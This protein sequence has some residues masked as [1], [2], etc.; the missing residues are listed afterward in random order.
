[1]AKVENSY[2]V[3]SPLAYSQSKKSEEGADAIQTPGLG[4]EARV[5]GLNVR[6]V[7]ALL[8]GAG[9]MVSSK[10][11]RWGCQC[12]ITTDPRVN[13]GWT[14]DVVQLGV[15]VSVCGAGYA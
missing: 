4:H 12:N 2:A 8:T 1:M 3:E 13:A 15:R 5:G 14:V 9:A 7:D 10:D 11:W 6:H